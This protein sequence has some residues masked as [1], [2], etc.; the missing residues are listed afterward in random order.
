MTADEIE[1]S[2]LELPPEERA[3]LAASLLGSL[4]AVL[5]EEDEGITEA[6]RRSNEMDVDPSVELSW[7]E[8]K[9][10]IRRGE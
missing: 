10:G 8:V 3:R 9:A 5:D 4:P 2:A 1:A 7:D 6:V